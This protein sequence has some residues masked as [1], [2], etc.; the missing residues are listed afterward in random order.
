MEDKETPGVDPKTQRR[1][2]KRSKPVFGVY[3]RL[4]LDRPP[5]DKMIKEPE[6]KK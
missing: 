4:G 6:E 1:K 5:L 3:R 2:G